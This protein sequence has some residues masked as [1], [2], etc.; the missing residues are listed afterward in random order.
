MPGTYV[1]K[2]QHCEQPN[3]SFNSTLGNSGSCASG[4]VRIFI[5]YLYGFTTHATY[6]PGLIKAWL[7]GVNFCK[8]QDVVFQAQDGRKA[9]VTRRFHPIPPVKAGSL[10]PEPAPGR[11]KEPQG[12]PVS[13]QPASQTAPPEGKYAILLRRSEK[14]Y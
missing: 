4:V 11:V 14:Q 3:G 6:A 13:R 10:K 8:L 5:Y 9:V 7:G 12:A 2:R 1:A